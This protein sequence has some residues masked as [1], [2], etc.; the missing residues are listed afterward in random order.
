M[1]GWGKGARWGAWW[2]VDGG[3]W[4][5]SEEWCWGPGWGLSGVGLSGR[6]LEAGTHV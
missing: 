4:E 5:P 2:M 6:R 3:W 1:R